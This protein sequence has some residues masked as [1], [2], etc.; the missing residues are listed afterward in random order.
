MFSAFRRPQSAQRVRPEAARRP[1]AV[2]ELRPELCRGPHR[3]A[4]EHL[5]ED[6][7]EEEEDV[8]HGQE[9]GRGNRERVLRQEG[10]Q[11]RRRS[12]RIEQ[13]CQT[14]D[15]LFVGRRSRSKVK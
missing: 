12:G 7:Q 10:R 1:R 6:G 2:P 11:R 8:R 4:R 14:G 9:E 3:K 15:F 13:E 5:H